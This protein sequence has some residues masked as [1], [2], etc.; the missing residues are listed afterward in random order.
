MKDLQYSDCYYV[1]KILRAHALHGNVAALFDVDT[2]QAYLKSKLFYLPTKDQG[3]QKYSVSDIKHTGGQS[4]LIKFKEINT[5]EA[6][7]SLTGVELFLPISTLPKLTGNLFY[8]YE[9]IDFEVVDKKLGSIGKV[10]EVKE[11]P[12]QDLLVVP[13]QNVEILI[14]IVDS[15]LISVNRTEKTLYMDLPDGLLDVYLE[16]S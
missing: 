2:P 14:P 6:A 4:F 16:E 1:G 12:A 7:E 13:Y 3:L 15:F 8:Y 10:R 5:R 11:M 9:I